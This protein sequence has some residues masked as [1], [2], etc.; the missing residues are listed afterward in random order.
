[1][2]GILFISSYNTGY[3]HIS[4]T[5]SVREQLTL[6]S[7]STEVHEADAFMLGGRVSYTM[8]RLYNKVAV[9]AP[10]LWK[11]FYGL[12]NIFPSLVKYFSAQ[13]IKKKF[14]ELINKTSPR[15]IVVV[16]PAY[17]GSVMD[18]VEDMGIKAPVVSMVADLDNISHLW[19]DRRCSYTLCPTEASRSTLLKLS[20]A[21][22]KIKVFGFPVRDRFN[23]F[24]PSGSSEALRGISHKEGL[25]FLI[26]NGSQGLKSVE[27]IS[28]ILL[29]FFTCRVIILSGNNAKVKNS[30]EKSLLPEF[31]GR[32]T[33]HG[34]VKNVEYYMSISD[35]LIIRA[36]PNVL[37]EAVNLCKPVIVTGSL[38]GQEEKNPDFVEDNNLGVVCRDINTL[39]D[40][41][42]GLLCNNGSRLNEIYRHQIS[43]RKTCA[44]KDIAQ[45]LL[46]IAE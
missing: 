31:G 17:V 42:N 15:L 36:S 11:I 7:P 25:T 33:I 8:S 22:E 46:S 3:G 41:V 18:L 26:M 38:T 14:T 2:G 27:K 32:I 28:R 45:F 23:H 40:I 4:I 20:I 43:F 34:F 1:M 5:E 9:N 39:P 35:I 12:G 29:R 19:A 30:L 13:S 10:L 6:L 44:A 16:H 37:M 21:D 24:D